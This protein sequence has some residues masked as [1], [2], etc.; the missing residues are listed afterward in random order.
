M[1]DAIPPA[2]PPPPPPAFT[3]PPPVIV[4]PAQPRPVKRGRG[5][6]IFAIILLVLLG[7]SM[8]VNFSQ[9]AG[10]VMHVRSGGP[11]VSARYAGPRLEE[12]VLED[13]SS[14]NKIA[15]IDVNGII[16]GSPMNQQG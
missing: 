14:A 13:N 7:L 1:D 4:P 8:L 3:P 6:M 2:T 5:W 10:S 16:T 15:V 11:V 9:F 12:A